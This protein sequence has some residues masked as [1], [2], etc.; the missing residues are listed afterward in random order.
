MKNINIIV[1]LFSI[2]LLILFAVLKTIWI[3]F[4]YFA[5]VTLIGIC[6]YWIVVISID[7]IY[8]YR[9]NLLSGF[10]L[11]C[12]KI[13]NSS[14]VTTQMIE[15]DKEIYIKKYK[16]SLVKEKVIEWVKI[17]FLLS[18]IIVSIVAIVTGMI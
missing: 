3:G 6:L 9:T 8:E 13:I 12:A 10:K 14:N 15:D 17:L 16:K 18:I 1:T 5:I 2:L 4:V 11:F 7:Y